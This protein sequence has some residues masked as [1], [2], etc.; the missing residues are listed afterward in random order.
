MKAIIIQQ[1]CTLKLNI[2]RVRLQRMLDIAMDFPGE[3]TES[4]LYSFIGILQTMMNMEKLGKKLSQLA[5]LVIAAVKMFIVAL[6]GLK[7]TPFEL[8]ELLRRVLQSIS[9][10]SLLSEKIGKPMGFILEPFLS[11][12]I[13]FPGKFVLH[14]GEVHLHRPFYRISILNFFR[15]EQ[16]GRVFEAVVQNWL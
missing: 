7:E 16:Y 3:L 15:S 6:L 8:V 5:P 2:S 10:D 14:R 11:L 13:K 4:N 12:A 9:S 1:I